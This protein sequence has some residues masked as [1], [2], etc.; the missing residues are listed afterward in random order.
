MSLTILSAPQRTQ[1]II[2]EM[3]MNHLGEISALSRC[4][5][6]NISVITNVG[7]AHIGNLGSREKIA[8]AKLEIID[9]M[10]GGAVIVPYEECLLNKAKHIR[11]YSIANSKANFYLTPSLN[12]YVSIFHN[13]F[14][15]CNA[16]FGFHERHIAS[17]LACSVA[18][19]LMAEIKSTNL[20]EGISRISSDNIRQKHILTEKYHFIDDCYNASRESML[21]AIYEF[22]KSEN[23]G[24]T[25]VTLCGRI[26]L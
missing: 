13:G 21:C 18:A 23:R 4:L 11:T 6:P 25:N 7:T 2:A 22:S 24:F 10:N 15:L 26:S 1:V 3:G 19:A 5:Q 12:E 16:K 14:F 20:I 9:G 17:C 8:E